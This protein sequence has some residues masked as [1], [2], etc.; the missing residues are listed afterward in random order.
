MSMREHDR[1]GPRRPMP[2]PAPGPF[3]PNDPI[4]GDVPDEDPFE[5]D[6]DDEGPV[7]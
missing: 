1:S 5:P 6:D 2:T 4:P 3:D 7:L